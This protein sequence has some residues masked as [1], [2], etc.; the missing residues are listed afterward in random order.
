MTDAG[1]RGADLGRPWWVRLRAALA[2]GLVLGTGATSTLAA[3][4]DQSVV[5]GEFSS[6]TFVVEANPSTPYTDD[7]PWAPHADEAAVLQLDAQELTPGSTK[8]A[9]LALRTTAGSIEGTAELDGADVADSPD[10]DLA[11]ALRYRVVVAEGCEEGAFEA[12]AEFVIGGP[13]AGEPLTSGQESEPIELTSDEQDTP[14][15][16]V[17]LC[18]ELSLP[19][20]ADNDLQGK[21]ASAQW[22]ITAI[23]ETK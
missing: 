12:G 15:Q 5:T 7:G 9:S 20:G 23:S 19:E 10:L 6:S 18:V 14:G 16:P 13:D 11:D 3:W 1:A 22:R 4:T 17:H 21:Q 8:Y 2:T